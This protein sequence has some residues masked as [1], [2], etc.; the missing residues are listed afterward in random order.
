M[1]SRLRALVNAETDSVLVDDHD[2]FKV[3]EYL[4]ENKVIELVR[5]P[6]KSLKIKKIT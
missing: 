5:N 1:L 4:A 6:D 2:T 3:I